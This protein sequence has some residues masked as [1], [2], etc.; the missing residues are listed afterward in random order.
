MDDN[1]V[2]TAC[3]ACGAKLSPDDVVCPKCGADC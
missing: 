2:T 1:L 3:P